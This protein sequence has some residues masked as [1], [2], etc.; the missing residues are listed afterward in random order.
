MVLKEKRMKKLKAVL[1][2]VEVLRSWLM[3]HLDFETTVKKK[4]WRKKER[5]SEFWIFEYN[6]VE[7]GR[8]TSSIFCPLVFSKKK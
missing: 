8:T 5:N 2:G 6:T 7:M 4:W 3:V 1:L